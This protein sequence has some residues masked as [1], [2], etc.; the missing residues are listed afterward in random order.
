MTAPAITPINQRASRSRACQP[1]HS[2]SAVQD[3]RT[4]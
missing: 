1:S 4:G 2:V 3:K